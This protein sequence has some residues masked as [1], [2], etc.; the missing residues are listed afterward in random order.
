[1]FTT[2]FHGPADDWD[3]QGYE[4]ETTEN[5]AAL[6]MHTAGANADDEEEDD[7]KPV[8]VVAV[9]DQEEEEEVDELAALDRLEKELKKTELEMPGLNGDE[10]ETI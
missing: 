7:G 6:G 4:D 1:M 5:L 3:A 2:A 8:P 10:D 9:A